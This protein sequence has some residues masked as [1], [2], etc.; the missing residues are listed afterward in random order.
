MPSSSDLLPQRIALVHEWFSPRSIGGAE[1]VVKEVDSLLRNLGREP[2]LASLIDAESFQYGSWLQ[3]R[4]V[5]TSPI[6]H[7]PWGCSHVQQYLPLL[8]FAIEQI[9]LSA[10]DLVISSSHLVAKGVL[11]TPDQLHVSYVHTPVRY[12]WDQMHA[13]LQ[14]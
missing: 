6:Q 8:P 13:Y 1:Q 12:A 5:L 4:S 7:L 10:A 11:T 9:D 3:D 14:R 2:Q